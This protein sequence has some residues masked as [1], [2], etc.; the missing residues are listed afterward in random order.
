MSKGRLREE[1]PEIAAWVDDL[2]QAFGE[3]YINKIIA[4]GMKGEPVFSVSKNG[5]TIGTPVLIG[6]KVIRDENGNPYILVQADGTRKRY[7][8]DPEKAAEVTQADPALPRPPPFPR[9]RTR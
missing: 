9:P 6:D 8:P 3:E 4:A 1:M 7:D 5:R 2:R